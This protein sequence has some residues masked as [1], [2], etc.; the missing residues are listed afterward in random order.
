MADSVEGWNCPKDSNADIAED[1]MTQMPP[2]ASSVEV[3][4]QMPTARYIAIG[5]VSRLAEGENR[6]GSALH[7]ASRSSYVISI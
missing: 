1:R 3:P 2:N 5:A 6:L 7:V 4:Y